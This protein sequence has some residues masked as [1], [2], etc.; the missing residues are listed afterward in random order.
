MNIKHQMLCALSRTLG[1]NVK[2]GRH[3]AVPSG[4]YVRCYGLDVKC[5]SRAHV[6]KA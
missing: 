6:L 2:H 1:I 4:A 5:P 3:A